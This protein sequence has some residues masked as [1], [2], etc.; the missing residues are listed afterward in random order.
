MKQNPGESNN[1]YRVRME[2]AIKVV[3]RLG[4]D[5]PT[6]QQQAMRYLKSLDHANHEP[7][8]TDLKNKALN[9]PD[10]T[11]PVYLCAMC[12]LATNWSNSS[13]GVRNDDPASTV[14]FNTTNNRR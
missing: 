8:F 6:P 5:L 1:K 7:M 2:D 13:V 4:T 3:K 10:N 12:E 14:V 9:N 11:Y